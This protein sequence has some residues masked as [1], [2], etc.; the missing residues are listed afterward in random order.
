M[1]CKAEETRAVLTDQP[2]TCRAMVLIQRTL[3]Q[4]R[5]TC[6]HLDLG[7]SAPTQIVEMNARNLAQAQMQQKSSWHLRGKAYRMWHSGS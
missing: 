7:M 5:L 1:L 4:L 2:R 6:M 3:L